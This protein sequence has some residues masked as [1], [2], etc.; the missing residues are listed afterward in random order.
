M[1]RAHAQILLAAGAGR[2]VRYPRRRTEF[3]EIERAIKVGLQDIFQPP[4]HHSVA[5]T[6]IASLGGRCATDAG[7]HRVQKALLHG[8]GHLGSRQ[9]V[10]RVLARWTA[11]S[12]GFN[13]RNKREVPAA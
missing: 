8:L 3:Q 4:H 12:C 6:G 7:H 11:A 5:V 9:E 1:R 13:S 2:A 10:R